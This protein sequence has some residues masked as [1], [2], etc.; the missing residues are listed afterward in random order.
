MRDLIFKHVLQASVK[1]D[2]INVNSIVGK[3]IAEKPEYKNFIQDLIKQTQEIIEEVNK[4]SI[5]ERQKHLER[6]SQFVKKEVKKEYELSNVKG[7]VVMRF[8]P[9]PSGAMSIGHSRQAIWNDFFVKKYKGTFI[10]RFDD[11]DPKIKFPEKKFYEWYK[12][13]M[14]YLNIK[15]DKTVRQ[16]S[17]LNIYYKYAEELINREKAYV[18]TCKEFNKNCPCRK[19]DYERNLKRWKDMFHKYKEGEA[20]LRI[21]TDINHPNPAIRDWIAFRIVNKPKHPY[22]KNKVW[23]LLNFA[24]AIDD[25]DLKVT[26]ILRG[27]D[28]KSSVERQNYIYEY[29]EWKYPETIYTGKLF[30]NDI[31]SKSEIKELIKQKKI[32][33]W[34]DV[35]LGTIGALYRR[36]IKAEAIRKFILGLGINRNDIKVDINKLYAFNKEIID[37]EA[38]RYFVVFNP[39][40]IKIQGFKPIKVKVPLH[41]DKKTGSREFICKNEFYVQDKIYKEELYR[42]MHL[43]NFK[44]G[45]FTSKDLDKG[46]KLIHWLPVSKN[47]V[48]VEVIMDD[49]S[50]IKGLGE[51]N[52]R[53]VKVDEIIQMERNFFA[54]LE[55]K[56]K[57]KFIFVYSH[58]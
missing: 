11:T 54:R 53:K 39:S 4:L 26:H 40:K 49:N 20:V 15:I 5:E 10:L 27:I 50:V 28:L 23:P 46:A 48:N 22:S 58:R 41:P 29:F 57:D 14:E 51:N 47:L 25:H 32:D 31:K 7:K 13:D 24:S 45:R 38:N 8:A 43:F 17:R 36:G 18:C 42:F 37:K 30:F 6:F 21:K 19:L 52:L 44:D 16:S 55:E 33:G 12:E 35:R 1:Y 9:N 34:D 2:N 56:R 3:I